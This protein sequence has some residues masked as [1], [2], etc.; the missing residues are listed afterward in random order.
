M[1]QLFTF[2]L[3][4]STAVS[5]PFPAPATAR[6]L[7]IRNGFDIDPHATQQADPPL[8][9]LTHTGGCDTMENG[10]DDVIYSKNFPMTQHFASYNLGRDLK[11]TEFLDFS[12]N[13]CGNFL[14]HAPSGQ[15]AGC[16]P[17]TSSD[18]PDCFRVWSSQ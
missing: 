9:I 4:V 13:H 5:V 7:H 8:E 14:Y 6:D 12:N 10:S 17:I 3:L 11:P 2:L 16:Y 18:L 15:K 1:F